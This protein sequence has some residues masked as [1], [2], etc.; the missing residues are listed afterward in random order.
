MISFAN[1]LDVFRRVFPPALISPDAVRQMGVVVDD[2]PDALSA[3]YILECRLNEDEHVD[4]GIVVDPTIN[5]G[6]SLLA[7][8]DLP[9]RLRT[10][11]IWQ[12]IAA[13]S[14][15][16]DDPD[17]SLREQIS[18]IWLEFDIDGTPHPLPSF[19]Y[20]PHPDA[21]RRSVDQATSNQ[22]FQWLIEALQVLEPTL[23][24]VD[25]LR[26]CLAAVPNSAEVF[27]LGLMLARGERSVRLCVRGK[28]DAD[29]LAYL[30]SL[31]W[32]GDDAALFDLLAR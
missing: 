31:G 7:A 3:G 1:V 20:G 6:R 29:L 32:K 22:P 8:N 17:Q 19:F 10:E 18:T 15:Q 30:P 12:K 24:D 4:L 23:R 16:W 25:N 9:D 5:Q 2:L 26:E 21:W 27:Q 14:R 28:P 13:F 11:P